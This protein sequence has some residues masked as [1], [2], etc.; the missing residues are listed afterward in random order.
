M[1]TNCNWIKKLWQ[2]KNCLGAMDG[3]RVLIKKP[4]HSESYYYN[5]NGTFSVV[6]FAIVNANC[7]FIYVHT[8]TNG[9]VPDGGI[10]SKTNI[11]E[12]KRL[13]PN[14][15]EISNPVALPG[16]DGVL[17]YVF[18]G[19]E[20]FPLMENVMKQYSQKN[21]THDER[22]FNYRL[23]RARRVVKNVFGI[24]A[25]RFRI[26]LQPIAIDVD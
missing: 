3:K 10:W 5:Y 23:S 7:Q 21:I 20:A 11:Y 6:L 13:V 1:G 18:I 17:P 19:D 16:T 26:L 24:L 12:Y 14:K 9:R 4:A 15:L 2:F 8:G 22:I 25:S